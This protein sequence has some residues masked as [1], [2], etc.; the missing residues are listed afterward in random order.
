MQSHSIRKEGVVILKKLVSLVLCL[1]II[2]SLEATAYALDW[3]VGGRFYHSEK[4]IYVNSGTPYSYC[5]QVLNEMNYGNL[6]FIITD[7]DLTEIKDDSCVKT[8]YCLIDANDTGNKVVYEFII[9]GDV[10]CSG[11]VTSSDARTV[12]RA[13]VN[14][15]ALDRIG[16]EAADLNAS[17]KADSGDARAILRLSVNYPLE[18]KKIGG[19]W[20]DYVTLSTVCAEVKPIDKN[21]EFTPEMFSADKVGKVTVLDKSDDRVIVL[22]TLKKPGQAEKEALSAE[23]TRKGITVL[24]SALL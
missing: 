18:S 19:V 12:L 23:L 21:G 11:K 22:L 15:E 13:A 7:T 4:Y 3:S 10:D 16:L 9:L 5:K 8:G 20:D 6:K 2:F 1:F 17:G 14:L 24:S